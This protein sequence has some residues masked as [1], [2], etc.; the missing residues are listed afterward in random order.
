[1]RFSGSQMTV[2]GVTFILSLIIM[3]SGCTKDA[4]QARADKAAK[5]QEASLIRKIEE[6]SKLSRVEIGSLS[7][8]LLLANNYDKGIRVLEGLKRDDRYREE[9]DDL[10]FNLSLFH[11]EKARGETDARQREELMKQAAQYLSDGFTSAKDKAMAFYK[12]AKAYSALGCFEKA[13]ADSRDAIRAASTQKLIDFGDGFF[14]ESKAF[15]KIVNADIERF[16]KLPENC[17]VP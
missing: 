15:I 8:I 4:D 14:L 6:R 11:F 16:E 13:I 10:Y 2:L 12:R 17:R 7:A 1:M 9:M 3:L 5:E